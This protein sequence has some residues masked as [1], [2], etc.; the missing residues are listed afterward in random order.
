[1]P[2]SAALRQG[3]TRGPQAPRLAIGVGYGQP[4]E[5]LQGVTFQE[6]GGRVASTGSPHARALL[7]GRGESGSIAIR[8]SPVAWESASQTPSSGR[9]LATEV[10]GWFFS[11][12]RLCRLAG[13]RLLA[14]SPFSGRG[15]AAGAFCRLQLLGSLLRRLLPRDGGSHPPKRQPTAIRRGLRLRAGG[16][17]P[18]NGG[19][20]GRCLSAWRRPK[21]SH[22]PSAIPRRRHSGRRIQCTW[23]G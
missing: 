6:L 21:M 11:R 4:A 2:T 14:L 22:L 1:M 20:K 10:T 15:M 7:L 5:A 17:E 8:G 13:C 23:P 19:S 16:F 9:R 3:A 18:P 12:W